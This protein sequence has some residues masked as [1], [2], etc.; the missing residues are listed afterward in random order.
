V[1]DNT[2]PDVESRSRYTALAK[3][4]KIPVRCFLMNTSYKQAR[5]N[6]K[7]RQLTNSKHTPINDM[8]VNMYKSKY[9]EPSC[10]EGFTQI[11][12]VNSVLDFPDE[13]SKRLYLR[14][15]LEK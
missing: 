8:V 3:S 2:N 5:H 1:I 4:Y 13:S 9:L 15:L 6:E 11:V 14:Y 12:R 7:Y 10:E